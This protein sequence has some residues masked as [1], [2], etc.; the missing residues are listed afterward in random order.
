M[1]NFNHIS[2]KL[3][4]TVLFAMLLGTSCE[5]NKWL[6][7]KVENELWLENNKT[8]AGIN[9]SHSGLQYSIISNPDP[10]GKR[11]NA[12]SLVSITYTGTLIDG[13]VFDSGTYNQYLYNSIEGWQEGIC[14]MREHSDAIF[15]IPYELAYGDQKKGTEGLSNFLPPYSTLIFKV[16]LN[17]V[18]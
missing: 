1:K 12:S 2:I 15:Y 8:N 6:D 7:W 13:T 14:Y 5:Q 9:T 11:P 18:N 10:L 17:S 16:H 4:A 3:V